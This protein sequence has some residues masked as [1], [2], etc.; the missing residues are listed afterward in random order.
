M[1]KILKTI[2][3]WLSIPVGLI[4]TLICLTGAALVFQ[5]EILELRYPSRY[6]VQE[7]K[8]EVVPLPQLIAKVNGQ[9]KNNQVEGVQ[10]FSDSSRNYVIT[11]REG[12]RTSA[13]VDPYSGEITGY[14]KP[15]ESVFFTIMTLHRWLMGGSD[16]WGKMIVGITT[17]IF[18][19]I[20]ISGFLLKLPV[21]FRKSDFSIQFRKGNFKLVWDLHNVLG[22]Y[23]F[24]FLLLASLTGLM[25]SFNWYRNGVFETLGAET[26]QRSEQHGPRGESS[27]AA[28]PL[29]S[30]HWQIILDELKETNPDFT[31]IRIQEGNAKVARDSHL[32]SR[33]TDQYW[34]DNDSGE[35][36]KVVPYG[37]SEKTSRIWGWAYDLHVGKYFGVWSKILAFLSCL[38]GASLPITGYI[39]Y[40]K[41]LTKRNRSRTKFAGLASVK[42]R[43]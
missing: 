37:E 35:L 43:Q 23:A 11:L 30:L 15:R 32:T 4:I 19:F 42:V 24:I 10:V 28:L 33:A 8:T 22:L 40:F 16:S 3:L 27:K 5:D 12:F 26:S 34:F 1:A 2:H 13:F 39:L 29:N 21:R 38:F 31:S 7:E 9:L 36:I 17:L 14:N 20:L 18:V 41:R 25:W 6:F